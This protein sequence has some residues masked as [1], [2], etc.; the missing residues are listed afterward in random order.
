MRFDPPLRRGRLIR[1]YKRFFV[2][3]ELDGIGEVVAHCPNTGSMRGCLVE[4]APVLAHHSDDPK[5]RLAWTWVAVEV[6]GVWIGVWSAKAETLV[7]EAIAEGELLP[8][9]AGYPRVATQ[10]AYGG[11]RGKRS[12]IDLLLSRG[13]EAVVTPGRRRRVPEY[14]GDERV[15]VEVKSTTMRL[16]PGVAAFPDAVTERGRKHLGELQDVVAAGHRA[17]LVLVIQRDDCPRFAPADG[18]DPA[19]G[20][21]LREAVAGGVEVYA[22]AATIGAEAMTLGRRLEIDLGERTP[23]AALA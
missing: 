17:A 14:R 1:R 5:R 6:D 22:V 2:D 4:G 19:W 18:I 8:E 23:S 10:V 7:A 20:A 3:L 16:G 21:A 13:G 15:Y 12:R 11:D 9:L